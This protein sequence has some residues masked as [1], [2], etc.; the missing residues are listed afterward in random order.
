MPK[1]ILYYIVLCTPMNKS[2]SN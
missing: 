1:F 2:Y